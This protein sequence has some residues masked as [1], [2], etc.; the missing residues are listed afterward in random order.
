ME[1]N[2]SAAR[3]HAM[4]ANKQINDLL[5]PDADSLLN[6]KATGVAKE[7]LHLPGPDFVDRVVALT[8][9]TPPVLRNFNSIIH[10]G[11]L[12]GTG[13]VSILPVDQGIEHPAGASL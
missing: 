3:F 11:R 2:S 4:P 5:G 6:Y 8:D 10:H 9:R 1:K 13:Y 7:R 12:A